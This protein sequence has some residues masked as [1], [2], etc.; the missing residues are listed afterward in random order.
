LKPFRERDAEPTTVG[1][2]A[3]DFNGE[4]KLAAIALQGGIYVFL[5]NGDETLRRPLYDNRVAGY[6]VVAADFNGR[7]YAVYHGGWK[8]W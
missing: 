6:D 7:V 3:G 4:G 1:R 5:G 8:N 2:A